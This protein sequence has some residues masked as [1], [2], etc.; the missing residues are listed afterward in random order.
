LS[1]ALVNRHAF[2]PGSLGM[3]GVPAQAWSAAGSQI[4]LHI[5][6]IVVFVFET[7]WGSLHKFVTLLVF[8]ILTC[9]FAHFSLLANKR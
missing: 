8:N 6:D 5:A 4:L 9:F 7:I 3:V 2:V 1:T